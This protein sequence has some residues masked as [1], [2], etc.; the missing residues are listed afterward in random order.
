MRLLDA[1]DLLEEELPHLI[2]LDLV[3]PD[4]DGF[5]V[6]EHLRSHGKTASI[7]VIIVTGKMLSYEDV[8]TPRFYPKSSCRPKAYFL[9][10]ESMAGRAYSTHH[11][12]QQPAS[13]GYEH[14]RQTGLSATS[15]KIAAG[16]LHLIELSETLGVSQQLH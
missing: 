13:P 10:A 14:A 9:I 11:L 4:V 5:Q 2:L 15:S 16:P 6:L 12:R 3:M 1:V 8:K 7:P